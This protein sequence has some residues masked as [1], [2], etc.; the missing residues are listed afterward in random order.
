V[1]ALNS[2][3]EFINIKDPKGK[4]PLQYAIELP[5]LPAFTKLL[6]CPGIDLHFTE[7]NALQAVIQSK[8]VTAATLVSEIL[9]I[10]STPEFINYKNSSGL[11]ALE[12][13]ITTGANNITL[14]LLGVPNIELMFSNG[15]ALTSCL[16]ICAY[17]GWS[18]VS[19][20][21][22]I[23][24]IFELNSSPEF[25]NAYD[26]KALRIAIKQNFH[27]TVKKLINSDMIIPQNILTFI[28]KGTNNEVVDTLLAKFGGPQYINYVDSETEK[29]LL[30]H[31]ASNISSHL[32][33][34]IYFVRKLLAD[35]QLKTA[36][37]QPSTGKTALHILAETLSR[38]FDPWKRDFD[39]GYTHCEF[40]KLLI[41]RNPALVEIKDNT[42][43]GPGNPAYVAPNGVIRRYIKS[44]KSSNFHW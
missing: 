1:L 36:Y 29:S 17:Y 33:T 12:Y 14:A 5:N 38:W 41:D 23:D 11:T 43:R 3:P 30:M 13:S 9:Q 16:G 10:N 40:L 7:T 26:N 37:R 22:I 8:I 39:L 20:I 34:P 21:P 31:I 2:S 28:T 18:E 44:R 15:T 4:C 24:K 25:L 42:G 27:H 35:P 6:Y 32:D 19:I